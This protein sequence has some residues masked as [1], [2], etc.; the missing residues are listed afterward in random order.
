M[1]KIIE[2]PIKRWPGKVT[3]HDPLTFP[4]VFAFEDALAEIREQ[5]TDSAR[6][7]Y[8]ALGGILPC[9]EE[10]GLSGNGFPEN[11]TLENFPAVPRASSHKL[12]AWLIREITDLFMESEE[13]PNE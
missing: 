1:G 9:V 10:W 8:A 2:S 13:V 5:G 3:L 4:M 11:V 12:I 6:G 7:F